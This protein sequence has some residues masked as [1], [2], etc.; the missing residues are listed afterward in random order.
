[1]KK[2]IINI[3]V[4]FAVL[5]PSSSY[6]FFV[7][8]EVFLDSS[9]LN[10]KT[11]YNLYIEGTQWILLSTESPDLKFYYKSNKGENVY[12]TK[13]DLKAYKSIYR[14]TGKVSLVE[15][16]QEIDFSKHSN[17]YAEYNDG[18]VVKIIHKKNNSAMGPGLGDFGGKSYLNVY[19]DIG[20]LGKVKF[21]LIVIFNKIY[22]LFVAL[23][24][25]VSIYLI[26]KSIRGW[27]SEKA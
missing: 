12:Y 25:I 7:D 23:G 4:V 8:R 17:I 9:R 6:A 14:Q 5:S 22:W 24:V 16:K 13:K 27:R 2:L 21:Y 15:Y 3:W 20:F 26:R 11:D 18:K 1:M 10:I 19:R